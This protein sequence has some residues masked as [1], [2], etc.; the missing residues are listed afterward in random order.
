MNGVEMTMVPVAQLNDL[1][2]DISELKQLVVKL[3]G[4][5]SAK[6]MDI[7]ERAMMRSKGG[8]LTGSDVCHLIG[9]HKCTLYNRMKRGEIIM[10]KDGRDYRMDVN[11]FLDYYTKNF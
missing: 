4:G 1:V 11:D 2:S 7:K 5:T 9:I 6:T 10:V 3:A 8:M